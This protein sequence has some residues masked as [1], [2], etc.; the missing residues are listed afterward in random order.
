MR[1]LYSLIARARTACALLQALVTFAFAGPS[2]LAPGQ[3]LVLGCGLC[4][5]LRMLAPSPPAGSRRAVLMDRLCSVIAAAAVI[6]LIAADTVGSCAF[7]GR[8]ALGV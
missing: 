6:G 2:A 1:A 3:L 8:L 4:I 5:L 7:L